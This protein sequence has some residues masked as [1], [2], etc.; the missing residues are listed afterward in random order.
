M[1]YTKMILNKKTA[2]PSTAM[3][4]LPPT[5][6]SAQGLEFQSYFTDGK[7][8]PFDAVEWE[9]R[10]ALIGNEKGQ[11][12]F[13]Q[14]NVEVPKSWSQTATNIVA[15]KYFHGKPEHAGTR[16]LR[17]AIDRP[18]G[19]HHRPLGR[20]G[21]LLC[22]TA[23]HDAFRD[24]LRTCSSSRNGLQLAGLVQRRRATQAAVLR[25]LHQ[26]RQGRHG[27]DHGPG[28]DRRHALQVGLG[29]GHEFLRRSA[30]A[31]KRFPAA[32]SLPARSAS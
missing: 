11:T 22:D 2:L 15:S 31:T 27:I 13:R 28:Q 9:R 25:L 8:S 24:D 7:I 18:R 16:N 10:T 30:A 21:R 14:E 5:S 1:A 23:S 26:F 4:T 3:Q 32:A 6:N 29:H 12:I 20:A 17:A 19:G